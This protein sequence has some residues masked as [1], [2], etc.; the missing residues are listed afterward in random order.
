V[1]LA[2]AEETLAASRIA[3]GLTLLL[4]PSAGARI[5]IGSSEPPLCLLTR[6]CGIRD[7]LLGVALVR[8]VRGAKPRRELYA[9]AALIDAADALIAVIGHRNRRALPVV[10]G[11]GAMALANADFAAR[12]QS[13]ERQSASP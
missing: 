5:W 11:A 12:S 4:A 9:E 13:L 7:L 10:T 8:A 3:I 2:Q 6:A 1:E